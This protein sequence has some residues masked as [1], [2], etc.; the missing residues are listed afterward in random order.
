VATTKKEPYVNR[1]FSKAT[2]EKGN[3]LIEA[4]EVFSGGFW[5]NRTRTSHTLGYDDWTSVPEEIQLYLNQVNRAASMR[6]KKQKEE[7]RKLQGNIIHTKQIELLPA[8]KPLTDDFLLS[9]GNLRDIYDK[10]VTIPK[11]TTP[12]QIRIIREYITRQSGFDPNRLL[13]SVTSRM[14]KS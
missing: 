12:Q 11:S 13:L 4:G 8:D 14:E 10:V 9:K 1:Y 2:Q 5:Q 7:E 6:G 3:Q